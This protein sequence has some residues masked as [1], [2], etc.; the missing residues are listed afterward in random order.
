MDWILFYNLGIKNFIRS[1]ATNPL[2]F[3]PVARLQE[4]CADGLMD[5]SGKQEALITLLYPQ[6]IQEYQHL[7]RES[8]NPTTPNAY[9]KHINVNASVEH[10]SSLF[11]KTTNGF[12][13]N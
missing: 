2:K 4:F 11:M 12:P 1:F 7:G 3:Y 6:I 10:S 5:L 13:I 9:S 8:V